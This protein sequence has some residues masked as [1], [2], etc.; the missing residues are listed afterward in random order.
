[1]WQEVKLNNPG[2]SVCEIGA[3]IG[4]MWRELS[5]E[6][7]QRHNDDFTLDKVLSIVAFVG[8]SIFLCEF[9]FVCVWECL[10][11]CMSVRAYACLYV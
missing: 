5:S 10:F 8:V 6:Q 1:M 7:K 4:S 2:M 11:V 3:T 9:V